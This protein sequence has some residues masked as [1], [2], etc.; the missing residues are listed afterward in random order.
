MVSVQPVGLSFKGYSQEKDYGDLEDRLAT[1]Y[2]Q[3]D[4]K[5]T[6]IASRAV[7]GFILGA[8]GALAAKKVY[9]VATENAV[10]KLVAEKAQKLGAAIA[11]KLPEKLKKLPE[12]KNQKLKNA[13]DF[14]TNKVKAFAKFGNE[15]DGGL[16]GLGRNLITAAGAIFG[17]QK[18]FKDE[19]N[20]GVSDIKEALSKTENAIG[21]AGDVAAMLA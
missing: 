6:N 9:K 5:G 21:L 20:N 1:A 2:Q 18:G 17:F 16:K 13:A 10:S 14:V 7:P 19:N 4:K 8:V 12:I 3:H 15:A 11:E